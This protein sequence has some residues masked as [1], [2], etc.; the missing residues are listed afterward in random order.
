MDSHSDTK[1]ETREDLDTLVFL[2]AAEPREGWEDLYDAARRREVERIFFR[3]EPDAQD[4][5]GG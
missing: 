1:Q 2:L 4:G 5:E 3:R